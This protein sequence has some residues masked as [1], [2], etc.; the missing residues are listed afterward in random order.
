[1]VNVRSILD[2]HKRIHPFIR[3][4]PLVRSPYLS[5]TSGAEV[6]LKLE[7]WQPT[8]SFKVRGALNKI[9]LLTEEE[10][11]RGIVTGSAGNHGLGVAYAAQSMGVAQATIF[12][13]GGAP[14]A[15]TD[16]MAQFGVAVH[17]V[18]ATYE[19]AHQMAEQY[20]RGTGATYISAYDDPDVVA[21]QGT[22]ALEILA[23][24]PQVDAL[25]VPI[26]GGGM[27]AGVSVA[28]KTMLPTCR[29]IG[30]Q[31]E[32]SPAA[33][34]SLRDGLAYDPYDHAPTI[35]DGL[36]GGFGRVPF[37]I[38]HELIDQIVLASETAL[39][40]SIFTLLDRHQLVVEASGAIAVAPLL[41]DSI[42]LK[43]KT[44]ICVL[45]GGNLDT[46]LLREIV[47]EFTVAAD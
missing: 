46:S 33:L 25:L 27:I 32:A 34:L 2:A 18:G 9:A 43:G 14:R 41:T 47:N 31:P 22:M 21:G 17:R 40:R 29:V 12:V 35:A 44:V 10:K 13:P 19:E 4:T 8:G 38:A 36:A 11:A 39:R 7:N 24:L 45:S 30:V 3:H 28:A 1:M 42:D 26:G 37:E 20:A 15:K 5:R 16:K 6:W 23:D